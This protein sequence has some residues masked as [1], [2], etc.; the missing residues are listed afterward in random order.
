MTTTSP[1][2]AVPYTHT[3]PCGMRV[4]CAPSATDVVYCGI[5]VDAGTRDEL[6]DENG[7]AHFCEHLT[8]KGTHRRRSWHILNRMESVGRGLE[9][10][11]G[12][13]RK[14]FTTRLS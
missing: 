8:F 1:A 4:I 13:K 6:P 3:L 2:S 9:R 12:Q 11:H 7:L 5:A 14:P 10:L